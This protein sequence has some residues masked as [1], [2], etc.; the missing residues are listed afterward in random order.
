MKKNISQTYTL[1]FIY[2]KDNN[3]NEYNNEDTSN[4]YYT[5][6]T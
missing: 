2:N 5:C 3:D 6:T 4:K 1:N